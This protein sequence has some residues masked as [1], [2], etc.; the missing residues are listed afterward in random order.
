MYFSGLIEKIFISIFAFLS[1]CIL[2]HQI[3][4]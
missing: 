2:L 4:C 1:D 3:D